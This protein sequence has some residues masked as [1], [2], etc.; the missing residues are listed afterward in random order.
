M[1]LYQVR[2]CQC[3]ADLDLVYAVF[4]GTLLPQRNLGPT[5]GS[6][7]APYAFVLPQVVHRTID[8][9][10]VQQRK[11]SNGTI[12]DVVPTNAME[13]ATER[14]TTVLSHNLINSIRGICINGMYMQESD[15]NKSSTTT[16]VTANHT[17]DIPTSPPLALTEACSESNS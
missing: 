6:K 10:L 1:Q 12:T 7:C 3:P 4:R 16:Y 9:V 5:T 17:F 15:G 11:L 8:I 13:Q 14:C 2:S